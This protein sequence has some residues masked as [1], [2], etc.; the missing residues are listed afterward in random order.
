MGALNK[1]SFFNLNADQRGWLRCLSFW[2]R[3][4]LV[5]VT[6]LG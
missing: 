2:Y 3:L 1:Q 6:K 5:L 4:G